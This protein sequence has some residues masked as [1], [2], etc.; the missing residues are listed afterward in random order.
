[1]AWCPEAFG[2]LFLFKE[3]NFHDKYKY[4]FENKATK[5]KAYSPNPCVTYQTMNQM[6]GMINVKQQ[7]HTNSLLYFQKIRESI[8]YQLHCYIGFCMKMQILYYIKADPKLVKKRTLPK[9]S[10]ASCI[11]ALV[12]EKQ[13]TKWHKPSLCLPL[14]VL[15]WTGALHIL[16]LWTKKVF[17]MCNIWIVF[18]TIIIWVE[19]QKT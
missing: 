17:V 4:K 2:S 19:N 9:T 12:S 8:Q 18:V 13:I 3:N 15:A 7:F 10:L 6:M 11:V 16:S 14:A 5:L 1:M